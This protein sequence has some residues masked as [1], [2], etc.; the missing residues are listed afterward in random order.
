MGKLRRDICKHF[1]LAVRRHRI[2]LGLSQEQL[3]SA[4]RLNRTYVGDV[5]RGIRNISLRNIEKLARALKVDVA[6]LF[7]STQ[8]SEGQ[9]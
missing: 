5:E 4:A 7:T 9:K 3:A 2:Q 1:G 6:S 8:E